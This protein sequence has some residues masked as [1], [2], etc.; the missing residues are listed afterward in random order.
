[1]SLLTPWNTVIILMPAVAGPGNFGLVWN[2][3]VYDH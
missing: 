3:G 1:M 2:P